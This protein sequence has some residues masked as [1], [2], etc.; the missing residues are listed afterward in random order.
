MSVTLVER[1]N[2]EWPRQFVMLHAFLGRNLAGTYHAIEHVGS[3]AV[4][5][6]VAKPVIDIDI[7]VRAGAFERVKT[8]LEAIGYEHEGDKGIAGREAFRLADAGLA[9][10]LPRHH[11]YV[12]EADAEELRRHLAF[13]DYLRAH[14]ED[15]KRLSDLKWALAERFDNDL[16]AYVDG[17]AALVR[18]ILD[19]ALQQAPA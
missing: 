4:P 16:E 19:A 8:Y 15:V 11:L 5:G 1:Y 17:K 2:P 18:E 6:M 12:L 7:V 13:R 14:P 10:A 9:G 3:T